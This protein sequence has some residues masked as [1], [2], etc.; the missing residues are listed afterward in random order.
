[1]SN[2]KIEQPVRLPVAEAADLATRAAAQGLPIP[3]Y[4]GMHVLRS[5]YG[6]MHPAALQLEKWAKLGQVGP[7]GESEADCDG[8]E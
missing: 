1:M 7:A 5:A 2:D 3:D 6:A 4:L 8:C